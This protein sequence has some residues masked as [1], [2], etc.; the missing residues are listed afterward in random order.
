MPALLGDR[1]ITLEL[2]VCATGRGG[3]CVEL[4]PFYPALRKANTP[5]EGRGH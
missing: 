2:D 5:L 3:E 1:R 4:S